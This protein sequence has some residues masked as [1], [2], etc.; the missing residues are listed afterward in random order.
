MFFLTPITSDETS[1]KVLG[2]TLAR[3]QIY[4]VELEGSAVTYLAYGIF[5]YG[6]YLCRNRVRMVV[7]HRMCQSCII[8][9]PLLSNT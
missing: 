2:N 8:D 5:F 9:Y 4:C 6:D 1:S 3:T 7:I